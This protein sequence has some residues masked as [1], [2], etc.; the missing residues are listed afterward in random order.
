MSLGGTIKEQL[1]K[2]QSRL[3]DIN[4]RW[5]EKGFPTPKR[6]YRMNDD[7][8]MHHVHILAMERLMKSKLGIT[9]DEMKLAIGEVWCDEMEKL[10]PLIEEARANAIRS[11]ITQGI[12]PQI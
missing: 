9:E 12:K 7:E 5:Q 10:E 4:A 8:F 3:D 11:Q 6:G 2:V 1:K